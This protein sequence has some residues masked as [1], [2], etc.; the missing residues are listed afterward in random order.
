MIY[1]LIGLTIIVVGYFSYLLYKLLKSL[2]FILKDITENF[3]E[4]NINMEDV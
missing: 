4:D 1:F 2:G 3:Q